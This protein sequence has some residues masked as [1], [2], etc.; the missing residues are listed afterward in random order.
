M[1]IFVPECINI[2]NGEKVPGLEIPD[3]FY[4]MTPDYRRTRAPVLHIGPEEVLDTQGPPGPLCNPWT[5]A[6]EVKPILFGGMFSG[7]LEDGGDGL[8]LRPVKGTGEPH[9]YTVCD[10]CIKLMN[11]TQPKITELT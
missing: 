4:L 10:K 7:T 5:T 2:E 8:G 6:Y 9:R 1:K 3:G 11:S